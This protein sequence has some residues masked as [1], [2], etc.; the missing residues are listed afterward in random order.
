M[1]KYRKKTAVVEAFQFTKDASMDIET[2]PV[3]LVAAWEQKMFNEAAGVFSINMRRVNRIV[4]IDDYIVHKPLCAVCDEGAV[5]AI[6]V[7]QPDVFAQAYEA[8][9]PETAWR[10]DLGLI[11]SIADGYGDEAIEALQ[12]IEKCLKRSAL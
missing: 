2:W 8:V 7:C 6:F 11:W 5:G 9:V 4:S 1:S 3:W 12:N 10:D